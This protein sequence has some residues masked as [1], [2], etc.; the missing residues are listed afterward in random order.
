[1]ERTCQRCGR[2]F[3]AQRSTARFCS[4]RCTDAAG[5]VRRREAAKRQRDADLAEVVELPAGRRRKPK[6]H[7]SGAAEPAEPAEPP[8]LSVEQRV[9]H[10]LKALVDSA[11]G[12]MCLQAARRLDEGRDTSAAGVASLMKRLEDM[13]AT[14]AG[15]LAA[16][17]AEEADDDDPIAYIEQRGRERARAWHEHMAGGAG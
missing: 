6:P 1:M 2:A 11:L 8:K 3:T 12:Q 14:A 10:E 9:R 4:K 5:K 15:I 16:G 17:S 7:E 13:L